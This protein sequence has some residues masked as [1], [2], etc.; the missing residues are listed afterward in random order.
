MNIKF[1]VTIKELDS[2]NAE[3]CLNVL[4]VFHDFMCRYEEHMTFPEAERY[5]NKYNNAVKYITKRFNISD[6]EKVI[7]DRI[8][9]GKHEDQYY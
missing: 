9:G 5:W 3:E 2:L 1:R 7:H 8:F 4:K 6:P